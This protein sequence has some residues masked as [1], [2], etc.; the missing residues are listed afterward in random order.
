[1]A[2]LRRMP[3]P[4]SEQRYRLRRPSTMNDASPV[5][6]QDPRPMHAIKPVGF[7]VPLV[8]FMVAIVAASALLWAVER[9]SAAYSNPMDAKTDIKDCESTLRGILGSKSVDMRLEDQ[10]ANHCIGVVSNSYSL[11]DYDVRRTSFIEQYHESQFVLWLVIGITISGV[12][13][14]GIQ[15]VS[16]YNMSLMLGKS[17]FD[18]ISLGFDAKS[19]SLGTTVSGLVILAM[20]FA[21]FLVY[22]I[23]V[24]P[25]QITNSISM[26]ASKSI[27]M[28]NSEQA[29]PTTPAAAPASPD[30]S[31]P[32]SFYQAPRPTS[33][34]IGK[35]PV[36][37]GSFP[38]LPHLVP[39]YGPSKAPVAADKGNLAGPAPSNN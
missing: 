8:A 15:L 23:Y 21:F 20:S 11:Q 6:E 10:I 22:V 29:L 38:A 9:N 25:V 14:A 30:S 36:M 37:V 27:A 3:M 35:H 28:P 32:P 4:R 1:M 19:I 31:P 16:A 34:S 12:V 26:N 33:A 18:A 2:G 17:A 39:Y 5:L 7:I 24:Y 13:L